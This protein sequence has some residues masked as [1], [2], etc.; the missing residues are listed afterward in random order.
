M[1]LFNF[2]GVGEVSDTAPPL[3]LKD[4]PHICAPSALTTALFHSHC[5]PKG[6]G[7]M[8]YSCS[9][10]VLDWRRISLW[11]LV[12]TDPPWVLMQSREFYLFFRNLDHSYQ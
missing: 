1:G 9:I 7:V 4:S 2:P 12:I 3:F 6:P 8:Y 5:L 10:L 11:F